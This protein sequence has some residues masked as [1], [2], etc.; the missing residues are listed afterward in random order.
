MDKRQLYRM[1]SAREQGHA[2]I[3]EW[4]IGTVAVSA[5]LSGVFSLLAVSSFAGHQVSGSSTSPAS[6]GTTSNS[7]AGSSVSSSSAGSSG[8]FF[9]QPAPTPIQQQSGFFGGGGV[10]SGAS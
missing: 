10:V 1:T 8:G 9:S 5:V 2:H 3:R 6:T 4:T 7:A